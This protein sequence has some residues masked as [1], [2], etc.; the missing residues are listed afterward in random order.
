MQT[1]REVA[2]DVALLVELTPLDRAQRTEDRADGRGEG[3]RAVDH[4]EAR[5]VGIQP[6]IH[7]VA[8]Q[9]LHDAAVLGV[10]FAQTQNLLSALA[11]DAQRDE[12]RV[13]AQDDPIDQHDRK[14]AVPER[15][16][17]PGGQ[18]RGRQGDIPTRDGALRRRPLAHLVRERVEA[19]G[20]LACRDPGGHG[21]HRLRIQR[22]AVGRERE[23][24]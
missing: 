4:K 2:Q 5:P 22:V 19:P 12:H 3:L 16:R 13:V 6:A 15:R 21:G 24:R 20:V 7:E 17:Q 1:L 10:P 23:A 8:E 18:L 9:R 11:I 14:V